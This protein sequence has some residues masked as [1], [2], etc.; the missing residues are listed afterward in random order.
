MAEWLDSIKFAKAKWARQAKWT[1]YNVNSII[2]RTIYRGFET[3]S[4]KVAKRKLR[5][6]KSEY[7][8]N[9]DDKI[10]TRESPHL[11]IVSDA[12]WY[13]ANEVVD[14]RRVFKEY[15]RG[16]G[17]P[18]SGTTRQRRG[19][20]A[21]VF[22]CGIRGSAMYSHGKTDGTFR[23]SGATKG[24]CWNRV[25]CMRERVFPAVLE[26]MVKEVLGLEGVRDAVLDRV[27]ELHEKGG[28]V[29]AELKR[30]EKDE[31]KL[32]G[33]IERLALAV[34]EGGGSISSLAR[35]LAD[36]ER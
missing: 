33:A 25:Y 30:Q 12:L 14:G 2:R 28:S 11:L 1:T 17:H 31:R 9:D 16:A 18:L 24:E 21:G 22:V 13:R 23:C 10:P 27:R 15:V 3:H 6:G 19:L 5:S 34:E 20:L 4:K 26:T 35:R 8:W 7:V 36:R 29:A 32:V